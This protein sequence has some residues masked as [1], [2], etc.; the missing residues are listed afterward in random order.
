M[1][2]PLY[3]TLIVIASIGL[4]SCVSVGISGGKISRAKAVQARPPGFPFQDAEGDTLDHIW[5]NPRN[6]NSISYLSEC[7]DTADPDLETVQQGILR[8]VQKLQVV[9]SETIE[10][11][12]REALHTHARGKVDGV[13]TDME[14]LIFK[15]NGCI[16]TLNYVGVSRHFE[17]N[18]KNFAEFLKTFKAP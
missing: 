1:K 7:T 16:Y 3:C 9:S 8:S 15:K 4:N 10:F 6:G 12:D 18:Q 13:S 2:T 5:K 11:N 17:S 14:L